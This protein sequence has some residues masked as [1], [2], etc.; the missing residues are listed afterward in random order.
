MYGLE[1]G[2]SAGDLSLSSYDNTGCG[3]I[4]LWFACIE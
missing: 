4:F 2:V 1:I 3:F